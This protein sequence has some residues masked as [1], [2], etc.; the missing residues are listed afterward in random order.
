MTTAMFSVLLPHK[1]IPPH[2][3]WKGCT[4]LSP[5]AAHAGRRDRGSYPRRQPHRALA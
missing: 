4:A 5:R 2:G 3:R 1:H